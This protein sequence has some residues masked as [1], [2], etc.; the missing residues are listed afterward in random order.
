M[1]G[2][3]KSSTGGAEVEP[4]TQTGDTRNNFYDDFSRV[5]ERVCSKMERAKE[6]T[7]YLSEHNVRLRKRGNTVSK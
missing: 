2:G 7:S 6:E 1:V 3:R 4:P 5:K